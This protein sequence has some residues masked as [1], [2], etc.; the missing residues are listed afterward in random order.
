ME[1]NTPTSSHL[2]LQNKTIIKAVGLIKK[3]GKPGQEAT[4]NLKPSTLVLFSDPLP[5]SLFLLSLA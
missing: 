4:L 1:G 3:A 5:V 2:L